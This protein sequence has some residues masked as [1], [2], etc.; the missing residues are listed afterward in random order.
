MLRALPVLPVAVV[1]LAGCGVAGAQ[2]HP[3]IAAEVGDQ[4]ITT[5]QVDQLSRD[6]CKG[7]EKL[8]AGQA[9]AAAGTATPLSTI[10]HQVASALVDELVAE[11][12]A[13][14]YD[15]T[16]SSDYKKNLTEAEQ[17]LSPVSGAAKDAILE[18]VD[19]QA[20]TQDVLV[21]IGEIELKKNGTEDSTPQ[22]QYNEGLKRLTA[23]ATDHVDDVEINPRYGLDLTADGP[24]DTAL[25]V[26]VSS[27][28]KD[29]LKT[30]PGESYVGG[31]SGNLVCFE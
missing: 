17:Q 6:S 7:L 11:Q 20:Y 1:L 29:G 15:V 28:A 21:Q 30:D 27:T 24:V 31:L 3:G 5:R 25:S 4:T 12:L 16:P 8:N 23:W 2:F 18:V 26:A 13:E 14:D 10:T 19:A 9:A 22:D